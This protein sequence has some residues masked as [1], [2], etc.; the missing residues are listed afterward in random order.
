MPITGAPVEAAR[1]MILQTFSANTSPS[2]PPNTVKSC[3]NTN[4]LRPSIV[5][6]PVT[7]PSP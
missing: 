6:H 5:P 4:T 3:E 7:T 2:A 1:S